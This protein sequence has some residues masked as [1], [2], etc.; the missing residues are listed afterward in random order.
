MFLQAGT[1]RRS[2]A[3]LRSLVSARIMIDRGQI[4]FRPTCAHPTLARPSPFGLVCQKSIP[5]CVMHP[6]VDPYGRFDLDRETLALGRKSRVAMD[7]PS[8]LR[9]PTQTVHRKQVGRRERRQ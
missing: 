8:H 7:H 3:G 6:S 1:G 2:S 9:E 5:L 4:I